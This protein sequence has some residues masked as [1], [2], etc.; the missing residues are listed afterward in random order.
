MLVSH[1][2]ITAT[3]VTARFTALPALDVIFAALLLHETLAKMLLLPVC[4]IK[5]DLWAKQL[6]ETSTPNRSDKKLR[7]LNADFPRRLLGLRF[8]TRERGLHALPPAAGRLLG[9]HAPGR[10]LPRSCTTFPT[11]QQPP[12]P[13]HGTPPPQIPH[14]GVY[15]STGFFL[16]F[17][18]SLLFFTDVILPI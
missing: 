2:G 17:S 1:S 13:P 3:L 14:S 7:F 10:P 9:V 18:K 12:P 6:D 16:L 11:P 8:F 4:F 5:Q 15:S